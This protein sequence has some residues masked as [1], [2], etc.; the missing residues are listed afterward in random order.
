MWFS[1]K[2][3]SVFGNGW[4]YHRFY[5]NLNEKV[6]KLS[7]RRFRLF[8]VQKVLS[9]G[10]GHYRGGYPV[11]HFIR[12]TIAEKMKKVLAIAHRMNYSLGMSNTATRNTFG[13]F[14]GQ[15]VIILEVMNTTAWVCFDDGHEEE[16]SM[17]ALEIL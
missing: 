11:K 14:N 4:V 7:P 15:S 17:F 6:R 3:S 13:I 9:N 16:V 10:V 8:E 2:T 1:T 12:K 5:E